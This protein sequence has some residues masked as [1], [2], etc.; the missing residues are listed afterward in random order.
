[1]RKKALDFFF[2]NYALKRYCKFNV[3][4]QT[5][6]FQHQTLNCAQHLICLNVHFK[7]YHCKT[8]IYFSNCMPWC[9]NVERRYGSGFSTDKLTP[10]TGFPLTQHP[11]CLFKCTFFKVASSVEFPAAYSKIKWNFVQVFSFELNLF[12]LSNCKGYK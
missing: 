2:Q 9:H 3:L 1:M 4:Y 6:I 12:S 5:V 10:S 7:L 8:L 11:H